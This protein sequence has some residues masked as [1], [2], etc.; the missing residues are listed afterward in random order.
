MSDKNDKLE[1]LTCDSRALQERHR[2]SKDSSHVIAQYRVR[3][4]QPPPPGSPA[5]RSIR[6]VYLGEDM[7]GRPLEVMAVERHSRDLLVIHAMPLREKYRK[8][9]EEAPR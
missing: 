6:I 3:F 8:R 1:A 4:E 2:I 5:S 7:H 9:Y